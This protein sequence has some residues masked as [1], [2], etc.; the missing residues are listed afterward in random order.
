MLFIFSH[1]TF[2]QN[3]FSTFSPLDRIFMASYSL[4]F[5]IIKFF[6][7][8]NLCAIY[9]YPEKTG[10]LLPEIYYYSIIGISIAGSIFTLLIL[11]FKNYRKIIIFGLL[12]FLINIFM[13]LHII[14]I[15]GRV[16]TA[17]RYSYLAYLGLFLLIT[18][19]AFSTLGKKYLK[20]TVTTFIILSLFLITTSFQR[21]KVWENGFVLYTDIISKKP[22][23]SMAYNNR[24]YL[25]YLNGNNSQAL[26]DYSHAINTDSANVD[27][28]YNRALAYVQTGKMEEAF[29]DCNEA[30][31]FDNKNINSLYLRGYLNNKFEKY[32][33]AINDFNKVLA[34]NPK[35]HFALYNRGESYRKSSNDKAAINDFTEVIKLQPG[36]ADAYNSR[37]IAYSSLNMYEKAISDYNEAIKINNTASY[38]FFNRATAY[39]QLNQTK[40]AC[41][42]YHSSQRL[43]HP[44]ASQKINE[45]C[46]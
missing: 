36:F 30:L 7:P 29:S 21:N 37:G 33:E 43:G 42:D 16:I 8:F 9:P 35:H 32:Q 17:E 28:Y 31:K 20:L 11:K 15:K 14:P 10:G 45:F 22:D 26:S 46:R 38:F 5:Y 25:Y 2:L 3:E 44:E 24:G 40:K 6:A 13:V 18:Y 23:F 12:F 4:S 41:E 19:L 1:F 27:S 34:K 39:I